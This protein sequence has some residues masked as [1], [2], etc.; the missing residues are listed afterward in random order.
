MVTPSS[1]FTFFLQIFVVI[2]FCIR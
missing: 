2:R 1:V